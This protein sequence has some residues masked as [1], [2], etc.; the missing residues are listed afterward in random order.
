[1]N[2]YHNN[3]IYPR[4]DQLL[5]TISQHFFLS[6]IKQDIILHTKACSDC[7]L[8]KRPTKNMVIY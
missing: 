3:L 7:Q 5:A 1:M 4:M 2:W 8:L 6:N